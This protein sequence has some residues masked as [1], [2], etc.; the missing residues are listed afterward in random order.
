[1]YLLA[2]SDGP[3]L[4]GRQPLHTVQ[5]QAFALEYAYG[6]LSSD[7]ELEII[8]TSVDLGPSMIMVNKYLYRLVEGQKMLRIATWN[9]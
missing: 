3:Y 4:V 2:E 1:M 9:D 6:D 5:T 7:P 8:V